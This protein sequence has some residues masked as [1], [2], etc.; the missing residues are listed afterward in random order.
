MLFGESEEFDMEY[1]IRKV[2][3]VSTIIGILAFVEKVFWELY[4]H[5]PDK[6]I[7]KQEIQVYL[8]GQL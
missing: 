2:G 7:K 1:V 3:L 8:R 4:A 5:L 6:T